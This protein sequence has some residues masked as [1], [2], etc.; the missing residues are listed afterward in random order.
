M[1]GSFFAILL[2]ATLCAADPLVRAV[3]ID[4]KGQLYIMLDSGREVLA[5]KVPGQTAF[6][7]PLISPDRRTVG[8]LV[9]YPYPRSSPEAYDPGPI[10]GSLVLYR[11][12]KILHQFTTEVQV[13]WDW[14]FH[15]DGKRVAYA[16]GP[17]HGDAAQC[18]LREVESGRITETWSVGKGEKAPLWAQGLRGIERRTAG[19]VIRM[20]VRWL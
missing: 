12:D 4:A 11:A 7:S 6:S 13:V 5:P 2:T 14:Q 10:A 9:M 8:W 15:D 3:R 16:T 20:G 19:T 1:C 17:T 18:V